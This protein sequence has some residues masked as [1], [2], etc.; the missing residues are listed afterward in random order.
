MEQHE[1]F[2][3]TIDVLEHLEIEYMVVGS[4]ASM[5]YGEPR[6]TLDIDIVI[7]VTEEQLERLCDAFPENDFYVSRDAARAALRQR[8]QFN[9]IRPDTG[10][11]IDFMITRED[12]WSREEMSGRR[13]LNLLPGREGFAARAE[14]VIIG[15]LIYYKEGGS[16]KHLRDVAGILKTNRSTVDLAYVE[17]WVSELELAEEWRAVLSRLGT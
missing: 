14:D 9:V 12:A 2:R 4:F 6:S 13:R 1:L 17:R 5:A 8:S 3:F 7:D 10:N 15:K 11:K 16:D